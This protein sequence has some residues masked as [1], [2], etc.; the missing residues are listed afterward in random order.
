MK[1]QVMTLKQSKQLLQDSP[2]DTK[3]E[4]GSFVIENYE[5][6]EKA[7]LAINERT[8]NLVFDAGSKSEAQMVR[9]DLLNIQKVIETKRKEGKSIL[10]EPAK[11]FNQQMNALNE[12]IE[13]ALVN[14]REAIKAIENNERE[15]RQQVLDDYIKTKLEESEVN[16][17]EQDRNWSN[18]GSFTAKMKLTSKVQKEIDEAIE[19]MEYEQE[20]LE[21]EL[22]LIVDTAERNNLLAEPYTRMYKQGVDLAQVIHAI[23]SDAEIT[24]KVVE[25][26]QQEQVQKEEKQEGTKE[27]KQN[28]ETE[29]ESSRTRTFDITGSEDDFNAL[30]GFLNDKGIQYKEFTVSIDD[31]PW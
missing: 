19:R 6:V 4:Q 9:T 10:E 23:N 3:Y 11:E 26:P 17:I 29:N 22:N 14:V 21:N 20:K 15:L 7:V 8:E 12:K 5:E 16:Y 25:I 2:L 13:P 1:N 28:L 31:L 27:I 30:V 18:A 24:K